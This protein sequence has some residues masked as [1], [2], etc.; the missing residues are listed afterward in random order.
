MES[1]KLSSDGRCCGAQS[2]KVII[3]ISEFEVS[4]NW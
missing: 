3:I 1:N 2:I 4:E